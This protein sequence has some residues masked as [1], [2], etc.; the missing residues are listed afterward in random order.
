MLVVVII[1]IIFVF[2]ISGGHV[3][4]RA[5]MDARVCASPGRDRENDEAKLSPV[6][7]NHH[8]LSP[9]TLGLNDGQRR[10][11]KRSSSTITQNL[12]CMLP[13]KIAHSE[14]LSKKQKYEIEVSPVLRYRMNPCMAKTPPAMQPPH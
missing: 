1:V 2:L 10:S 5:T 9:N 3:A 6:T 11:R 4:G 7:P 14:L 12:E 8:S 13:S